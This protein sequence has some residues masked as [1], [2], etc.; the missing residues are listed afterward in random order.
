MNTFGDEK[1]GKVTIITDIE[2]IKRNMTIFLRTKSKNYK[3]YGCIFL[4]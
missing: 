3:S 1:K 2:H 4:E